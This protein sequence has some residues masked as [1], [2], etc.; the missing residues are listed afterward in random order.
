MNRT[1][2]QAAQPAPD[3]ASGDARLVEAWRHEFLHVAMM[4]AFVAM[5][6]NNLV[7]DASGAAIVA[8]DGN[9]PEEPAVYRAIR[10]GLLELPDH[11][12]APML[13]A[14]AAYDGLAIAI[15]ASGP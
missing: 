12:E 8:I 13:A 11:F 1:V 5:G 14:Q 10:Q 3:F 4:S 7:R 2:R 15:D 6:C 9:L